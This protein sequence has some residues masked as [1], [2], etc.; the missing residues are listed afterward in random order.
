MSPAAN[1]TSSH[2][3]APVALVSVDLNGTLLGNPEATH[4]FAA[5]WNHLN[6]SR[7]PQL[8]YTCGRSLPEMQAVVNESKL[9]VPAAMIGGLGTSLA[10]AGHERAAGEF[11][12]RFAPGWRPA[13]IE[14]LFA[15]MTGL[16]REA[17]SFLHPYPSRWYWRN[18][19]PDDLSRLRSRL[20]AAGIKATMLGANRQTFEIIPAGTSKGAALEHLCSLLAVPLQAVVVAGDTLHDASV[21]RLPGVKR[22]VVQNALPELEAELVGL[23]KF[24][25]ARVLADGVMD[26][27]RH[28]GVLPRHQP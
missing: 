8:V 25:A 17:V 27:L 22:I 23:E 10:V 4:R 24:L 7:R 9:P 14:E 3:P 6:P 16:V 21:L 2:P 1:D 26:G 13:L 11:N 18:A 5:A 19:A 20:A 12:A 15:G 28:F